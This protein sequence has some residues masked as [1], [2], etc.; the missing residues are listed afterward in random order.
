MVLSA[1]ISSAP[2]MVYFGQ[3]VG[4]PGAENA[5]FGK[6]TRTSIF[7]Y[8]GVPNHQR[9]VNNKKFD[10]GQLSPKE[11]KLRDFYKHLLNFTINSSALM[12]KYWELHGFNS[13]HT[14]NYGHRVFS[15][16]RWSESEKLIIVNNFDAENSYGFQLALAPQ[17]IEEWGLVDGEY[18]LK[19]QLYNTTTTTLKVSGNN[20]TMI[21]QLE[22]L[23]SFI[24]S[25]E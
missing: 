21:V 16:A 11:A 7:D 17:L 18:R 23:Q 6:P 8:I 25:L 13:Q 10:G 22:P 9:W 12:G 19:D 3:E 5:G 14:E 20:A 24:F 2:T 4:E 1:T 15:F